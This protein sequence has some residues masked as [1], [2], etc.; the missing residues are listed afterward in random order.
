MGARGLTTVTSAVFGIMVARM[1][2][3]EAGPEFFALY[4]LVMALPSLLQFQDLG[5][6]AALVIAI[7][8]SKDPDNPEVSLTLLSVWRVTLVTSASVVVLNLLMLLS[9]G[10]GVLLGRSGTIENA[11][12][13]VFVALCV[14]ASTIPMSIWLR[15]LLGLRRNHL[16]ILIQGMV[17]PLNF[18]I[19][20]VML[21]VGSGSYT[22]LALSTY[23]AGLVVAMVGM[24][25][26]TRALPAPVGWASRRLLQ[27]RRHP[28]TRVMDIGWPMLAQMLSA[29][30]SVAAQRYVLAHS[31][32]EHAVA[33]YAAA[34][35]VF[36]AFLGV[37]MAAGVALWP[38]FTHE[39]ATGKISRGPFALSA[40]MAAGATL[41]CLGVW[42]VREPLFAFTTNGVLHVG[43]DTVAAFG[44]M[45]VLQAA[46]YPLGMFIMDKPG[47]R[48]QVIPTLAMAVSSL[49]L[50][51]VVTPTLGVVGPV[52]STCAC[53]LFAQ[54]IPFTWYILRHR[55]RLWAGVDDAS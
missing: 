46:L 8:G 45:V 4:A 11:P 42:L 29:P 39:R 13:A 2:L 10:W 25:S 52:L 12:I 24:A 17:A 7:A 1:I 40:A 43:G 15:I 31:T 28:S 30:L 22:Y 55:E 37:V 53:V 32:S 3:G 50:S 33:E 14:W 41:L 47:I 26:A 19:V 21:Q 54:I 6:G 20:W 48:F 5:A 36:F 51:M 16:S 35:Q 34:A 23:A 38:R 9:G 18:A 44:L 27:I 49:L